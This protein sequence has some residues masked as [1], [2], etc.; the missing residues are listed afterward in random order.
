MIYIHS[1]CYT[2][3]RILIVTK[4]MLNYNT[5]LLQFIKEIKYL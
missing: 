5:G 1:H 2:N 3:I 4:L